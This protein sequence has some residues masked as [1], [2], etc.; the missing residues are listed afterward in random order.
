MAV[1]EGHARQ[2]LSRDELL[3]TAMETIGCARKTVDVLR[4]SGVTL[5][6]PE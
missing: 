5:E 6:P 2:K 4:K 3:Q 1:R